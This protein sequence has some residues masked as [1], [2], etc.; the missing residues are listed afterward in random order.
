MGVWPKAENVA[1]KFFWLTA[2]VRPN[3]WLDRLRYTRAILDAIHS[4]ELAKAEYEVYEI[5]N[6]QV[7]TSVPGVPSSI[8]NP[9]KSWGMG[10]ADFKVEVTKLAKLFL[11]NFKQYE[12]E[13]TPDVINA[14]ECLEK[15]SRRDYKLS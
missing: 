6:L 15:T 13:A 12:D 7:P 2:L 3:L 11:E 10:E 14:R 5:F 9:R 4:A 1:R 8:L